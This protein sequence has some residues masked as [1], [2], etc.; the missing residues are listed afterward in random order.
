MA[1]NDF[2]GT[3][4]AAAL[5]GFDGVMNFLGLSGGKNQAREYLPINPT[6]ADHKPGSLSVNR[7]SGLWSDFSTDDRGGDG[8]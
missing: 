6:R 7:D 4:A 3:V 1:T 5:A 8:E 2:I